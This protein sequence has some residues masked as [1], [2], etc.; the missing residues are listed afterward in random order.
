MHVRKGK[1]GSVATTTRPFIRTEFFAKLIISCES[2]V[3]TPNKVGLP[4]G[5]ITSGIVAQ[6][7]VVDVVSVVGVVGVGVGVGVVGV[8]VGV[9]G[10]IVGAFS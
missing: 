3:A 4:G 10:D 6:A 8:G 9:D 7:H 1:R 2:Y 5:T